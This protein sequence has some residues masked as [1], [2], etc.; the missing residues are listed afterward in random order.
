MPDPV[1]E[2]LRR[3]AETQGDTHAQ[4]ALAAEFALDAGPEEEREELRA[5]LDAAAVLRWFDDSLLAK[6]LEIPQE[7]ARRRFEKLKTL[8]FVERYRRRGQDLSDIHESTRLGWRKKLAQKTPEL[9]RDLSGRAA[10]CFAEDL[11]PGGRIEWIYHLLCGDPDRGASELASMDRDWS[12][13]ARTEDRYALAAALNELE[14]T[15]LVQNRARVWVLLVIAGTRASRGE[16]AQLAES[17]LAVLGYAQDAQDLRAEAYSQAL[18]GDVFHAQGRMQKA[19]KAYRRYLSITMQL[20][21]QNPGNA[22]SQSDLADAHNRIGIA[23]QAKGN[24]TEAQAAYEKSLAIAK[25]LAEEDRGN[26]SLQSDLSAAYTCLG[27]LLQARTKF[28][29]A[30]SQQATLAEAQAA[31]EQS[32]S[33]SGRLAAQD[34]DNAGW[35]LALATA[36]SWMGSVSEARDNLIE[37]QASYEKAEAITRRLAEQ[38]PG[39]VGLQWILSRRCGNLG[40][41][42]EVLDKLAEAKAKFGECLSITRR[43]AEQATGNASWQRDLAV[44]YTRVAAL[45]SKDGRNEAAL[46]LYEE[47]SRIMTALVENAPDFAEWKEDKESVDSQL[48][49]CRDLIAKA[50]T[51]AP[52]S[53]N[54]PPQATP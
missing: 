36:H 34:P 2:L 31:Y 50:K 40:N 22:G 15:A 23:Q 48:A 33:I 8:P 10:A 21:L 3:L 46:P 35:Q 18:L 17:A 37:A 6:L 9:F 16:E 14:E 1:T 28:E 42:L 47:A 45:E 7:E 26:A 25:K 43:L 30:Q 13:R 29:E 19:Q 52:T 41:V 53:K 20:A 39:H 24:L 32:L 38:D 4:S 11:T 51:N 49:R 27:S 54:E 44:A 5:A 12:R